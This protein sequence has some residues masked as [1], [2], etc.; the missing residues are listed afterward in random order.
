MIVNSGAD[1]CAVGVRVEYSQVHAGILF[2]NCQINA[3]VQV[4]PGSLGPIKFMNCGMFGL[5]SFGLPYLSEGEAK[6][7]YVMNRG[8]GRMTFLGCHFYHPEG[9]FLPKDFVE[10]D[11][12]AIDTESGGLTISGCDFTGIKG[13]HLRLGTKSRSTL[14]TA[15]R[16]LG[17]IQVENQGSGKVVMEGNLDE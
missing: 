10:V 8:Q 11:Y 13:T 5:G 12:P 4:G 9:P 2:T 14:V 17:E 6:A 16:F 1:L 7:R 3:G 15:S